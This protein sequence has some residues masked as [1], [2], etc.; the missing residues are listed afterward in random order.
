[1]NWKVVWIILAILT[2]DMVSKGMTHFYFS[3]F[4]LSPHFFP[5]GGLTVFQAFGIDFCIHH[6]TNKGIAW[7][8]GGAFQEAIL[9]VRVAI[10]AAIAVYMQ[11]SLK[12]PAHRYPLALIVAGGL[13]NILDYFIY[14]HVIDMFH[15]IFWG[16]SYPVFNVADASI[17]LGIAALLWMSWKQSRS[18][19]AV[20]Q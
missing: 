8:L 18:A 16:Y 2:L 7:G 20:Q 12:A 11:R 10:I 17:F 13:G 19:D 6:V 14:G 15:F 3:P 4:E 1:M 5:F 9:V